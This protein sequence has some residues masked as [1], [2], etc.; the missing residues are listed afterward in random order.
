MKTLLNCLR[1][2]AC[3]A[4]A[5]AIPQSPTGNLS[6]QPTPTPTGV[7]LNVDKTTGSIL[8]PIVSSTFATANGLTRSA[9]V[10]NTAP[11][12]G[13]LLIGNAGGTAYAPNAVTGD[14]TITSAGVTAIGGGKVTNAML[15]GS[16]A[17]GKLALTGAILN[18][19]LAG[20]I[21]ASK[22]VGTDIAT[23][24]TV[25]AGTWNAGIISG[26]YGGTGVNNSGK[27]ITLGG[28]FATSGAFATT[29]TVTAAT[30]VILP[31]TGTLATLA[32]TEALSNKTITA[33]PISGSTGAFTTLAASG[34][35]TGAAGSFAGAD[36]T[37]TFRVVSTTTGDRLR[38]APLASGS[39]VQ[40]DVTDSGETTTA[41]PLNLGA[42]NSTVNLVG[43][44]AVVS[45]TG[46]AVAGTGSFSSALTATA[47]F[48]SNS[49][50]SLNYAGGGGGLAIKNTDDTS[51]SV[52]V[53]FL[54][55]SASVTGS[56][57][58]VTTT[59]AVVYNTTSDRRIK[60]HFGLLTDS[61]RLIDSLTPRT[62][63]RK[64]GSDAD[65][66]GWLGFVAQEVYAADPV[67]AR[68]GFVTKGDDDPTTVTKTWGVSSSPIDAILVAE[69][70]SLRARVAQ[71]ENR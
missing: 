32:G 22:L 47:G 50:S 7:A 55:G 70:Q 20:S 28:N 46:L 31:T 10:P 68:I 18:A 45:S 14:V 17:Y 34:L 57:S 24:G 29:L 6:A 43:T 59:N 19:D 12:A 41:R 38:A 26:Q 65:R 44:K 23:V 48:V 37:S 30:N 21:A 58:R 69:L 51:G 35:F 8:G 62:F 54:N 52:Y 16:I 39:G 49:N 13:A 2:A 9:I 63:D 33:S 67:F 1:A 36:G 15:A 40:I 61:G 53:Y 4:L 3:I 25:T 5:I 56:I 66:K 60:E 27:T 42:S 11:A 71:L 64:D